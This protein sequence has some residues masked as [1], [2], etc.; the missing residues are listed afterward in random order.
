MRVDVMVLGST[1]SF[2]P[3]GTTS[4]GRLGASAVPGR[5]PRRELMGPGAWTFTSGL[6]DDNLYHLVVRR[7]GQDGPLASARPL[8]PAPASRHGVRTATTCFFRGDDGAAY[9][10]GGDL[11]YADHS[12]SPGRRSSHAVSCVTPA[13]AWRPVLTNPDRGP[14]RHGRL[15]VERQFRGASSTPGW[16]SP[17]GLVRWSAWPRTSAL[18]PALYVPDGSNVPQ[19]IPQRRSGMYPSE[20]DAH[21]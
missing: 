9:P 8:A 20:C 18:S 3:G 7:V 4:D 19:H 1:T 12:A 15:Y 16:A 13:S 17:A 21:R 10:L 6:T 2:A 11:M 14:V 5:R